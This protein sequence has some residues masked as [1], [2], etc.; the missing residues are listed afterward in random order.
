MDRLFK[1]YMKFREEDFQSHR[2]MFK[3]ITDESIPLPPWF[4]QA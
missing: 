3:E 1:G 4:Q 2:E